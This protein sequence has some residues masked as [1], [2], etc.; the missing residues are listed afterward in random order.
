MGAFTFDPLALLA[1][2]VAG[3]LAGGVGT[4]SAVLPG[5]ATV[6]ALAVVNA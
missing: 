1:G 5:G 4:A 2:A 6:A 3:G